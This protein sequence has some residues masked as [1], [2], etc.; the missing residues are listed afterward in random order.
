M[1]QIVHFGEKMKSEYLCSY[2]DSKSFA[3]PD[4]LI[5]FL[6]HLILNKNDE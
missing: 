1:L 2:L 5:M 6:Y 3:G 4:T